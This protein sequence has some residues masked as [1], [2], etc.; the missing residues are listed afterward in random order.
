MIPNLTLLG[1]E[2]KINDIV[3]TSA[4]RSRPESKRQTK[5]SLNCPFCLKASVMASA[6]CFLLSGSSK[7]GVSPYIMSPTG[8]SC[9]TV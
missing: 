1:R 8:S 2:A 3:V 5:Q 9:S 4:V 6:A 7:P